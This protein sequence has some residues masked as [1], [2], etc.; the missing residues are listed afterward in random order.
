MKSKTKIKLSI[1]HAESYTNGFLFPSRKWLTCNQ[2]GEVCIWDLVGED[3]VI[4][5]CEEQINFVIG[6]VSFAVEIEV[7]ALWKVNFQRGY[8]RLFSN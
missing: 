6:R 5:T 4:H 8:R 2:F 1:K 3:H 7:V